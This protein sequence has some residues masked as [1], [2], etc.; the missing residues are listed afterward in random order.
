MDLF[1]F[2]EKHTPQTERGPLQR[3]SA[4]LFTSLVCYISTEDHCFYEFILTIS[5]SIFYIFM[6]ANTDI[7]KFSLALIAL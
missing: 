3:V 1:R 5:I 7:L 4:A 6:V 2:R